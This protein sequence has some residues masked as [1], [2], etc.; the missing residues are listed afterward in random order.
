MSSINPDIPDML[1]LGSTDPNDPTSSDSMD[2][3]DP[4]SIMYVDP[5][6]NSVSVTS[7]DN[8]KDNPVSSANPPISPGVN[9]S[10]NTVDAGA[11]AKRRGMRNLPDKI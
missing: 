3:N 6:L 7:Q 8:S 10:A 4:N 9:P 5:N 1:S 11:Q 2:P